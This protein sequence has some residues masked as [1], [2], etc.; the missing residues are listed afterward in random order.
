MIKNYLFIVI[1]FFF[2]RPKLSSPSTLQLTLPLTSDK[3]FAS[4]NLS[5]V[6]LGGLSNRYRT[7]LTKKEYTIADFY[8]ETCGIHRELPFI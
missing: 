8:S 4:H 5:W 2:K 7:E 1:Y 6:V 3:G